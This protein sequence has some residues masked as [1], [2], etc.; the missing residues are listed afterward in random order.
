VVA[1]ERGEEVLVELGPDFQFRQE[2]AIYVC[3]SGGA[4]RRFGEVFRLPAA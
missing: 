4:V 1:V 2:D 3:G